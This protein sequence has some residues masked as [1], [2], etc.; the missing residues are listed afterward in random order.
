MP[1]T[2]IRKNPKFDR[3]D[4]FTSF[5]KIKFRTFTEII[6]LIPEMKAEIP[7]L[8]LFLKQSLA[9]CAHMITP[10]TGKKISFMEFIIELS[11]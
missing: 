5:K 2:P 3:I 9:D 7:K 1:D 4:P 6:I 8:I 11:K 10:I